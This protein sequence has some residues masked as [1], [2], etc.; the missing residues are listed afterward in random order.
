M[1]FYGYGDAIQEQLDAGRYEPKR[2]VTYTTAQVYNELALAD[3]P[4]LLVPWN[5]RNHNVQ[6]GHVGPEA[7]EAWLSTTPA[8]EARWQ[9]LN[10]TH[11]WVPVFVLC[12]GNPQEFL[13]AE[14]WIDPHAP[15]SGSL[16]ITPKGFPRPQF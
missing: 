9:Y 1:S 11:E 4:C 13:D 10:T 3:S 6:T 14:R 16:W 5:G 12:E 2:G 15:P 8:G 7:R